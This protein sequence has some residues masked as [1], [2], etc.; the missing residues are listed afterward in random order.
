[1]SSFSRLLAYARPYR[2][3]LVA[4]VAAMLCYAAASAGVVYLIKPIFARSCVACHSQKLEKPAGKLVLD[5]DRLVNGPRWDLGNAG[6]L[7]GT[8]RSWMAPASVFRAIWF[9]L[10]S[11]K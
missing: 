2:G 5:D 7:P 11:V 3:R 8:G 9:T 10:Y 4:A 6:P 1:M